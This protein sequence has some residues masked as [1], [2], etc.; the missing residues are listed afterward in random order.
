MQA[1]V[2]TLPVD[3]NNNGTTYTDLVLNRQEEYL[4]R[5]LY[6]AAGHQPDMRDTLG[7]YRT[8]PKPTA[9]FKGVQ[10]CS[11]KFTK[12]VEVLNPVGETIVSP[13]IV[14]V[15]FSAPIGASEAVRLEMAQRASAMAGHRD[16][17]AGL[18]D[19]QSI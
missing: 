12:D 3:V 7:L 8:P 17:I 10:R 6:I 1:N 9:S 19:L 14:E 4:H 15:S 11:F 5:S 2:I 18:V 16:V 13:F